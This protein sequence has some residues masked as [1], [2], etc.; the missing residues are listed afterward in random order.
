[1]KAENAKQRKK[2]RIRPYQIEKNKPKAKSKK[3]QKNKQIDENR[4]KQNENKQNDIPELALGLKVWKKKLK[5]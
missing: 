5:N 4:N 2:N 1:M 3:G